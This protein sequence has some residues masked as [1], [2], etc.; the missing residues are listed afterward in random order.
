MHVTVRPSTTD[1]CDTHN[2]DQ[3]GKGDLDDRC[4]ILKSSEVCVREQEDDDNGNEEQGYCKHL[5]ETSDSMHRGEIKHTEQQWAPFH[6]PRSR[7]ERQRMYP[8]QRP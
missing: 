1:N 3:E 5:L 7:K 2:N 4:H 6:K 8:L